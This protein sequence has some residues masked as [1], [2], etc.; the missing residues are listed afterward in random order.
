[1]M[2]K[3]R[4]ATLAAL[5]CLLAL[6]AASSSAR[7]AQTRLLLRTFG[8]ATS[9]VPDP[10]PLSNPQGAAVDR[11][12]GDVYVAD[13]G[14]SRVE[15]FDSSG[16]FLLAFGGNVGGLGVDV[17][18]GL[19]TCEPGTPGSEPG[20]FTTAQFLAVDDDPSSP[21]FHDVYVADTAGNIVSKFTPEGALIE[22]WGTKGQLT[23]KA[24][25]EP[26]G[27]IAGIAV[28]TVGTLYVFDAENHVFE[29]EPG[30]KFSSELALV[31]GVSP[32]G[33][34][35]NAGGD[36]F[37]VK[38]GGIIVEF[39]STGGEIGFVN[40]G[41]PEAGPLAIGPED[42]L[43]FVGLDGSL[44]HDAFEAGGEV[45]EPGGEPCAVTP[46]GACAPSDSV[47]VGFAGSGIAVSAAG[48]A[49]LSNAAGGQ[50]DEYGPLVTVPDVTT[51]AAGERGA[52]SV[53][54]NGT[55]NPHEIE[56]T[57]C[58]FEYVEA[59]KYEPGAADPYEAG[60][61]APC[62]EPDLAEINTRLGEEVKVHA[63]IAGL[64]P[65][66]AYHFRLVG[67]NANDEGQPQLGSDVT[68]ETQP[69]PSIDSATVSSLTAGS[70]VLNAKI[71]PHELETSYSFEYDTSPYEPGEA[72]HGVR[73]PGTAAI[74]AGRSADVFVSAPLTGLQASEHTYYWRIVATSE[75]GTTTSVQHTFFYDTTGE[76]LPDHRA[77]EMVSPPHKNGADL[78]R[79]SLPPQIAPDG[80]RV[81]ASALQCFDASESC[82]SVI[83]TSLGA[84]YRFTRTS[85][86]W[87]STALAPSA[88]QFSRYAMWAWD[89]QSGSALLSMPTP[90][91][92]GGQGEDDFYV[93]EADGTLAHLGPVTLPA[94]GEQGPQGGFEQSTRPQGWTPGFSHFAWEQQEQ[95][96]FDPHTGETLYE[97][98]RPE[99]ALAGSGSVRPLLVGVTGPQGSSSLES[100]CGTFLGGTDVDHQVHAY[101]GSMSADGRTIF[102]TALHEEEC[103]AAQPPADELFARVDGEL[104]PSEAHALGAPEAHTVPI[105]EPSALSPAAPYPGCEHEPCIANVN[106]EANFA[107]AEFVGAST[108]ASKAFF[109]S[110]QQLTDQAS[111]DPDRNAAAGESDRGERGH[112]C[113]QTLAVNGCNLYEY[114]LSGGEPEKLIDLSAGDSSGEGPRVQGVL[115]LSPDASH[116]YFLAK[117]VL[118][119]A[120]NASGHVAHSGAENLYLFERDAAFPQGRTVFI[121]DL[122]PGD[123]T[124]DEAQWN[125]QPG[126]PANITPDGRFLVFLSHGNL[127]ADDTSASGAA[128]VFRYDALSGQLNRISIG[129]HGW[130]DNGNRSSPTPCNE[131]FGCVEDAQIVPALES[132]RPDPTMSDD[133]SRVFFDSPVGLTP[134]A[135]DD[136]QIGEVRPGEPDYAQN[137]YEWESE[138]AGSCPAARPAGCVFLISDGRDTNVNQGN[139]GHFCERFSAVCLLGTDTAG[140]NVFLAT[141]NSLVKSDTNTEIDF[142]DARI[143]EP[144]SPCVPEP[145]SPPP[146]CLGEACHGIPPARSP[147]TAGPT[148]TFNGAGNLPP[149]PVRV[150]S[151]AEVRAAK[152]AKALRRCHRFRNRARRHRCERTAHER[153]GP[154]RATRASGK[155]S[156]R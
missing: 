100:A 104:Q 61:L 83:G 135:R 118:T 84:P 103:A 82:N 60:G 116:V 137:V 2:R 127:T 110:P 151:A 7:A 53:T 111:E 49:F 90:P 67:A 9:T 29:F 155:G 95:F 77:Y 28:D 81:I 102:F 21:S 97:Y 117:G 51:E 94:L 8:A 45:V 146:P 13:T 112:Q 14:N 107:N 144:E 138:G 87:V 17:C 113:H 3:P 123:P 109:L 71:D 78:S 129:N 120:A 66:T 22:S 139:Y 62:E 156:T 122:L 128:Q 68:T 134:A 92:L 154:P 147:S 133:G 35:V 59:A 16:N 36:L 80:S 52:R 89:A 56:M 98:V 43:Y 20:R 4:P 73:V 30:S 27:A 50:I 119:K 105:S 99:G 79:F 42:G 38:L 114:D 26:F 46:V 23:G 96:A 37:K 6:A 108:D 1:M 121:A 149:A 124:G 11:E 74:P 145:P 31:K 40:S 24:P 69:A 125:G 75:S 141:T 126:S 136:L 48:D 88:A 39:G 140:R 143:C 63:R 93:R 115:A 44:T 148:A 33:L 32:V 54:L 34:A 55:V 152:L 153:Y 57:T 58:R 41:A 25:G 72:A 106:E 131:S 76:A 70:A 130:D 91:S 10:A 18:G 65:A 132:E 19:V 86:G 85:A 47:P 142:Y 5:V 12:T 150:K 15:K 101:P 64:T